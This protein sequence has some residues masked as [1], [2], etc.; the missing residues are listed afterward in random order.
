MADPDSMILPFPGKP[1]VSEDPIVITGI[2][3]AA[4]LGATREEVWQGV[5]AGKSGIRT[6]NESDGIGSLQLPCGMVDWLERDPHTLKSIQL[7][8]CVAAE[9]LADANIDMEHVDRNRFACSISA[10]FGDIGYMYLPPETRDDNPIGANGHCWWEQFLPCSATALVA[11]QHDLRGP[12]LCHTTACASGL[13]STLAAARMIQDDQADFALCGAA[14]AIAEMVIAAFNRMGV[15][16]SGPD[17]AS[18]CR[19]FDVTRSGFVMGEGAGMMVLE[20]RSTAMARGAQIYAEIA[21]TQALCQAHHV[22]GLDSEA[23]TL[24]TLIKRL[25]DRAGWGFRGPQY[26]NAHGTGTE[27]ND[28]SELIAVRAALGD[29]ANNVVMSSNKAVVG[30][31][32]NAAGSIELALT[33][34][35]MRDGFAPPTMYLEQPETMGDIDCL[36]NWGV[37]GD[38][39]RALKLSLA[40]GGHLVG[41]ALRRCPY[42]AFQ[43]QPKPLSGEARIRRSAAI[44]L[45][46]VA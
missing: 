26:I 42:A 24:T 1:A 32:I 11:R 6:I 37:Q 41:M 43:R 5:Q 36:P 4:S 44:P 20:K 18:A 23:E 25:V 10:Q 35:A 21:A 39:D 38:I 28:R 13:V 12:R 17:P 3:I 46:R 34:M 2:G 22:T 15:L 14:D 40:F 19:P 8:Q 30:H 45:R 27:Q 29:T 9:A 31:L 7:T 16:S 33:A